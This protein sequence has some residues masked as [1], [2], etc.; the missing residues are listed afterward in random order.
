MPMTLIDLFGIY[1]PAFPSA[2][3]GI[4]WVFTPWSHAAWL[5][6]KDH[7]PAFY[8]IPASHGRV[9]ES[10]D[11][12]PAQPYFCAYGGKSLLERE[13]KQI[14]YTPSEISNGENLIISLI[15]SLW[16]VLPLLFH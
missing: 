11:F 16:N 8:P 2:L 4:I 7:Q 15:L 5:E 3:Q 13:G 14:L 9:Y 12:P 1:S 6:A 10:T